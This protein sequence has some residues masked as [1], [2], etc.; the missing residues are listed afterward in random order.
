MS[1]VQCPYCNA[2]IDIDHDDGYGYEEDKTFMQTCK[3]V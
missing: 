3:K 2:D 1:D